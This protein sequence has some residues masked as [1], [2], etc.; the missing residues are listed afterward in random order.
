MTRLI[1]YLVGFLLGWLGST[2]YPAG[3]SDI[4]VRVENRRG[5]IVDMGSGT[6]AAG[7]GRTALVITCRHI[8]DE[9]RG[10]ITVERTDHSRH[11][12]KL[13]G[14][15]RYNDLAALEIPDPGVRTLRL[16][17]SQAPEATMIGFGQTGLARRQAGRLVE[18]DRD[19]VFYSFAPVEGDSGGGV[20]DTE[21]RL[22]GV[23]WG[24]DGAMGAVVPLDDVRGALESPACQRY[25]RK[26]STTKVADPMLTTPLVLAA[27]LLAQSPGLPSKGQP[28]AVQPSPQGQTYAPQVQQFDVPISVRVQV[29]VIPEV[30]A[31][32]PRPQPQAPISYGGGCYGGSYS[33]GGFGVQSYRAAPA[34]VVCPGGFCGGG[35]FGTAGL[36]LFG[37][38]EPALLGAS[39]RNHVKIKN[40]SQVSGRGGLLG[41]NWFA[42]Q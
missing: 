14:L 23:V 18:A 2:A 42:R 5:N 10:Q 15:S 16:A 3:W 20:F 28:L 41:L 33:A 25:W 19:T 1:A 26:A 29:R 31:Y 36:G 38:G 27:A 30:E 24:T 39:V 40:K 35:T 17:A 21:G 34:A 11:A 13:L 12:A 37:G 8:F 4:A 32:A 22:M 9:G 7:D 6:L